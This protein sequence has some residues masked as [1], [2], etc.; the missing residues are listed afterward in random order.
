[1]FAHSRTKTAFSK[2]K[3]AKHSPPLRYGA[4]SAQR[5]EKA[6]KIFLRHLSFVIVSSSVI[7]VSS[8]A[9]SAI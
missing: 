8:F 6:A 1:V 7:R 4:A 9:F 3:S 5:R 2:E